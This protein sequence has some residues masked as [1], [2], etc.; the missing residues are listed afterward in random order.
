MEG[1]GL[2]NR[3]VLLT[4]ASRGLGLYIAKAL[5]NSGANIL[6]VARTEGAL[7]ELK[8][9]LLEKQTQGQQVEILVADLSDPGTSERILAVAK[10][11]WKR[12]DVL[13]NNAGIQGPIGKSWE[14]AWDQWQRTLQVNLLSSVAMCRTF[15]P[16]MIQTGG[17]KIIN[18]SGGGATSPRPN[19]SAYATAKAALVR[20][21]ET[22]AR[23]T[24][25]YNI[26]VNCI[27]PGGMNTAMLEAIREAGPE[28]AGMEE[29][30]AAMRCRKSDDSIL[31]RAAAL[32]CYLASDESNGL[33]GKLISAVWDPW[34]RLTEHLEELN[35]SDIYT[36]RRITPEDRG[37]IWK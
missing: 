17:G 19:F 20:F 21:S 31:K 15:I 2:N 33:T 8:R 10:K 24:C 29:F 3:N 7:A 37:K 18:L 14:N 11:L 28:K 9:D 16:W 4:G 35:A 25:G 5:W 34:D 12:I 32:C 1:F 13:I 26:Q 30:Q 23:E 22:L 6:L 36:L 27:A